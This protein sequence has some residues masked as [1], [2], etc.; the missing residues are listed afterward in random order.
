MRHRQ[1]GMAGMRQRAVWLTALAAVF[2]AAGCTLKLVADYDE[3]TDQA[4][5]ALQRKVERFFVDLERDI[6]TPD[7]DYANHVE[8]YDDVRADLRVIRVR[9]AAR[10]KN[11]ITLEQLDLLA[12]NVDNLEAL[13]E[14]G[15]ED[16]EELVPVR[17]AFEQGFQAI[18]TLE[19]AKKRG[20]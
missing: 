7:A 2:V 17:A 3:V 16:R 18:L 14:L 9:A 15:F 5:T 4:V 12:A 20:G 1:T 13:H 8:F 11:E 10:P 19:L 6:P